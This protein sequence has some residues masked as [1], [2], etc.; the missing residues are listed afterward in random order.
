MLIPL[1]PDRPSTLW[2]LLDA[3][4]AHLQLRVAAAECSPA[5][6]STYEIGI[7]RFFAWWE[8]G[9]M[10]T[11]SS[12]VVRAW[13]AALRADGYRTNTI[14][15]WLAA[16]RAF[17]DWAADEQY[18]PRSPVAAVEGV[19]R[20]AGLRQHLRQ[21]LTRDEVRR[22]LAAP[23]VSTPRGLRD[24][25]ILMLMAYTAARTVEIHRADVE[26]L[27][28]RHDRAVLAV[29]G[30]GH[31]E[32]DDVLVLSHPDLQDALQVWLIVRGRAGG[33]LFISL[34]NR[35][36]GQRLSKSAIRR[37]VTD[38][39]DL[40]G[41]TGNKSTHSLRHSAATAAIQGNAPPTKVQAMLRHKH[42]TTTMI[43]YHETSR[44]LDAAEDYISYDDE[45]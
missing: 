16:V 36:Y 1:N 25:A 9:G 14:N 42:I 32:K 26:D 5:T 31:A 38:Y 22:V 2:E 8:A 44:V 45:T 37:L 4:R 3:W 20:P 30:K 27:Q 35:S 39:F 43:Y 24:R 12:D 10:P 7:N 15:V 6:V 23:D 28:A 21:P 17:Y 33:P 18:I 34:S 13:V 29:Q 41:V 19:K 11:I 40:A